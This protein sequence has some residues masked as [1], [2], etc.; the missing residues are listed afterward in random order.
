MR[1]GRRVV[2]ADHQIRQTVQG[3]AC[4]VEVP[5][6]RYGGDQRTTC[7]G[8]DEGLVG[9]SLDDATGDLATQ[10]GQLCRA[11][12]ALEIPTRFGE[13]D[14]GLA[15]DFP[16]LA[17]WD[18]AYRKALETGV[19][20]DDVAAVLLARLVVLTEQIAKAEVDAKTSAS[21]MGSINREIKDLAER[22]ARDEF[23]VQ[24]VG[25][26]E[27]RHFQDVGIEY[28]RYAESSAVKK[29]G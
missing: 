4:R 20:L 3:C 12:A 23:V 28:Y 24:H 1:G 10:V 5:W 6:L 26:S 14:L 25:S 9:L 16:A 19:T 29:A 22:S 17:R 7:V 13:V 8:V 11:H 15:A 21:Q 27:E 2:P 18:R